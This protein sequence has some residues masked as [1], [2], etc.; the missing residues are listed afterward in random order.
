MSSL[1]LE[2]GFTV[3]GVLKSLLAPQAVEPS[4]FETQFR[5]KTDAEW[6]LEA[7]QEALKGAG[8]TNPNPAVGCVIVKNGVELSRGYT[9]PYRG[10]HAERVA[11]EKVSDLRMLEGATVYV[12]LEPCSH[13]GHQK[14]CCDLLCSLPIK[15]VVIA[16]KDSDPRVNGRGVRALEDKGIEVK[17]GLLESEVTA[18]NLPFF[19]TR[20]LE[21]PFFALKWAQTLDG[22]LADDLGYSQWIS[23]PQ[24]R[25]YTH[26]LRQKYDAILV[27]AGTFFNEFPKLN[28]RDY[29]L[30]A[31][32]PLRIIFDPRG[33]VLE[34]DSTQRAKFISAIESS[35]NPTVLMRGGDTRLPFEC[36]NLIDFPS[37]Q[38]STQPMTAMLEHLK[39][40]L[41]EETLG[42]PLQSVLVE[43][44]PATLGLFMNWGL[45]DVLHVFIGP[46]VTGGNHYRLSTQKFLSENHSFE[47]LS[48]NRLGND[49]VLEF[50]DPKLSAQLVS[51]LREVAKC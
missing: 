34:L 43:G 49:T 29:P 47:L 46:R 3:G 40:P 45:A 14:P 36:K 6:M 9:Q 51:G 19:A 22:Q 50:I 21:R 1:T 48:S 41:L 27:G 31:R 39:S 11:I 10:K 26:S 13:Q 35:P 16:R 30:P 24:S 5:P 38:F 8:T 15:R 23:N 32:D 44:G 20:V 7:F 33:R 2:T 42:K 25:Q 28:V 17:C 12:T 37:P 4:K 18:F